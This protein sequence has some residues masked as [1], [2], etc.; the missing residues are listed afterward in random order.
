[1]PARTS[2]NFHCFCIICTASHGIGPDGAPLGNFIPESKRTSHL[3]RAKAEAEVQRRSQESELQNAAATLFASTLIDGDP[4]PYNQ[5]SRLWASR[6]EY[7]NSVSKTS[8]ESESLP[9]NTII[10]SFQRLHFEVTPVQSV[11]QSCF[12]P[13]LEALPSDAIIEGL[14]CLRLEDQDSTRVQPVQSAPS[15]DVF[16]PDV[17]M[18][19]ASTSTRSMQH[20]SKRERSHL[21][22]SAHRILDYVENQINHWLL[23]LADVTSADTLAGAEIDIGR[24]QAVF[25]KVRRDVHSIHVRKTTIGLK[26]SQLQSRFLELHR[27]YPYVD[28]Q[29]LQ[30]NSGL[31][32]SCIEVDIE[33][34]IMLRPP[35]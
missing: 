11:S 8:F 21:T 10:E 4:N 25:D 17:D 16:R 6:E 30:F 1:M 26:L 13:E 12:P 29:P 23:Q 35:L 15:S 32:F 3:A 5:P 24:I 27:L 19:E 14:Q 31:Y 20:L 7:Q 33:L 18:V 28:D 9:V 2:S 22:K 34:K